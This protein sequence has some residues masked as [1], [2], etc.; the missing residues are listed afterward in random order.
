MEEKEP[1]DRS[2]VQHLAD[3]EAIIK[4]SELYLKSKAVRRVKETHEQ[5]EEGVK[6]EGTEEEVEQNEEDE[7]YGET[8]EHAQ[9]EED[10]KDGKTEEAEEGIESEAQLKLPYRKLGAAHVSVHENAHEPV[11]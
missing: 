11:R 1:S 7:K 2:H 6:D 9:K 3:M 8:E 10:E 4:Q 5:I